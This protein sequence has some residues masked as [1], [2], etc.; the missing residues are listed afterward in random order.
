MLRG[1][2]L[3]SRPPL[4]TRRGISRGRKTFIEIRSLAFRIFRARRVKSCAQRKASSPSRKGLSLSSKGES[5]MNAQ[6]TFLSVILILALG[7]GLAAW[8][9]EGIHQQAWS[10]ILQARQ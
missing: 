9:R 5:N 3:M 1:I 4:L 8:T 7:S 10:Y 2:F 6:T